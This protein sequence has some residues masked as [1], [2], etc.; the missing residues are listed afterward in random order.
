MEPFHSPESSPVGLNRE[1]NTMRPSSEEL[2]SQ[3]SLQLAVYSMDVI[4]GR[5]SRL[6]VGLAA[7]PFYDF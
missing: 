3:G 2:S 1:S 5:A 4:D 6:A 7:G